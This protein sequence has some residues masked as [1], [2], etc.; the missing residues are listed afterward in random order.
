MPVGRECDTCRTAA[1]EHV[2]VA[3][4]GQTRGGEEGERTLVV[5][6]RGQQSTYLLANVGTNVA[7]L[8]VGGWDQTKHRVPCTQGT[9]NTINLCVCVCVSLT[10]SAG[11]RFLIQENSHDGVFF[12]DLEEIQVALIETHACPTSCVLPF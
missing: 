7:I 2:A 8:K 5:T 12:R 4:A 3:C 9:E 10:K 1:P 11:Q 6:A